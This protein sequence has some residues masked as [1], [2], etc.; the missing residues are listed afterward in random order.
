MILMVPALEDPPYP[1]LGPLVVAWIEKNLVFG[2]GDLRGQPA[3]VDA[4]KRGLIARAYE[5]YPRDHPKTGRRRFQ[6]VAVSLRKGSA[7]SEL[8]AWLAL[9]ELH[10]SAPVRCV[11]WDKKGRPRGGPVI[12]PYI[13]MVATTEEQSEDIAYGALRVIAGLSPIAKDLDIGMERVMRKDGS[14]KAVAL[15]AA[16]DARDGA[17]TT[18]NVFDETGRFNSRK[19]KSAH[20]TMLANT[21]KRRKADPWSLE[22]TTAPSPGEGSVAERTMEYAKSILDGQGSDPGLFYFHRQAREGCDLSTPAAI[23]EAVLEASGPVAAWSDIDGIVNQWN[24][25]HADR[26]YLCRMWLNQLVRSSDRAFDA[27]LWAAAARPDYMPADGALITLGFD[28]A[29]SADATALVGTE[30]A[31]GFQWLVGLWEKPENVEG[32]QV[33]ESEVNEVLDDAFK[34]WQV[35]RLYAD[36]PYWED[37]VAKWSGKYGDK[38]AVVFRTSNHRRMG[39][40]IRAFDN[41]MRDGSLTHSGDARYTRHINNAFRKTLPYRDD[42]GEPL[43]VIYKERGDSPNK[44]DGAVAGALSWEARRGA[45]EEGAGNVTG[46]SIWDQ[47]AERG[48][49]VLPW[50]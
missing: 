33:P 3:K 47:R 1:T 15:A 48:E 7:K 37:T 11:G 41:A 36:P 23:R 13:P 38:R 16:P 49:E 24:D 29:R 6:R 39:E 30:V 14:G 5:V 44:I 2:P 46:P 9:A 19:L 42:K 12:D 22:I 10:S 32:W 35:W 27:L 18:F 4:E 34:R 45:L 25:P 31:S 21:P 50:A 28:G 20:K 8:A 26:A 43:W 17:R 40:V